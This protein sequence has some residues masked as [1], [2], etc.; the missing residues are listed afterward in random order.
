LQVLDGEF[1]GKNIVL[2][3]GTGNDT[4]RGGRGRDILKGGPGDDK[5]FGGENDD[6]LYGD[7]G[8]DELDGGKGVD[9]IYAGP[10]GD[11]VSGGSGREIIRGG[12]DDDYLVAGTRIYGSI[13][14]G[15]DGDDTIIGSSGIDTLDGE[16]GNDTILGGDMGDI[17]RGGLGNDILIG[18]LGRDNISGD[19][20]EDRIYTHLNNEIRTALGLDPIAE[21][22]NDEAQ[23]RFN[24]LVAVMPE[25]QARNQILLAIPE[26]QR[27]PENISQLRIVQ[28][29]I[30]VNLL[31]QA[32]LL[33]YQS[34]YIDTAD[35]GDDDDT[36]YGSPN[37]D[38]LL[39]GNGND[40]IHASGGFVEGFDQQGDII[41][42]EG[43]IDTL[44]FD[45]TEANDT[46]RIF[47]ELV[48]N[49]GNRQIVIEIN[50]VREGVI[51]DMLTLEAVGVQDLGG[52]DNIRV[53]FGNQAD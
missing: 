17:I 52:D 40:N 39:G 23:S 43:D 34:V 9:L 37:L 35:G 51:Q 11:I 20:G 49:T 28:D 48:G 42:G 25:L 10:G 53:E 3:G 50:G 29:A 12:P 22:T 18:E 4:L 27:T 6:A 16:G 26:A 32:D 38:I 47:S 5:L 19:D 1:A 44:W 24:Q 30:T 13:I 46:I 21:F 36:I 41:K 14:S 7:E 31:S 2:D 33:K 15:G 8:R 45:G